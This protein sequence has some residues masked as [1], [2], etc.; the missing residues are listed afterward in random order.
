MRGCP[1]AQLH[2]ATAPASRRWAWRLAAGRHQEGQ[3]Q[4]KCRYQP[5]PAHSPWLQGARTPAPRFAALLLTPQPDGV[6]AGVVTLRAGCRTEYHHAAGRTRPAGGIGLVSR[7]SFGPSAQT[8]VNLI[9]GYR[10]PLR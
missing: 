7:A 3:L 1:P 10:K 2:V 8:N 4:R 9:V 6:W 5:V